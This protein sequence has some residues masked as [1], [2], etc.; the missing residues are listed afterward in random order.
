MNEYDFLKKQQEEILQRKLD[1]ATERA[2]NMFDKWNDVTGC[3]EKNTGYYFEIQGCIEDAVK[4]GM[5]EMTHYEQL[6]SEK[7]V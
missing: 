4:I 5:Q 1:R 2:L 7:D 6:E 3:F